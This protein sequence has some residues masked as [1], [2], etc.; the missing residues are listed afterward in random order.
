M[1]EVPEVGGAANA[2]EWERDRKAWNLPRAP[3]EVAAST[4]LLADEV[5]TAA[6]VHPTVAEGTIQ[7]LP[8]D[9]SDLDQAELR[10][11]SDTRDERLSILFRRWPSLNRIEMNEIRQLHDERQRLARCIGLVRNGRHGESR[12]PEGFYLPGDW[13]DTRR[14]PKVPPGPSLSIHGR[15]V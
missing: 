8:Q 4:N 13:N 11:A 5:A 6:D 7:R 1:R 2:R 14:I 9:I 12:A 3:R 15:E 10:K